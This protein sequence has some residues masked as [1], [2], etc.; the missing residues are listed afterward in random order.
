MRVVYIVAAVL[1]IATASLGWAYVVMRI[2]SRTIDQIIDEEVKRDDDEG[3][4]G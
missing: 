3:A 2:A 1:I 4:A